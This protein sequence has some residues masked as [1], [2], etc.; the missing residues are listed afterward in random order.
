MGILEVIGIGTIAFIIYQYLIKPSL[1][2]DKLEKSNDIEKVKILSYWHPEIKKMFSDFEKKQ[3]DAERFAKEDHAKTFLYEEYNEGEGD[4]VNVFRRRTYVFY[5]EDI[6]KFK[7]SVN[8]K[9]LELEKIPAEKQKID[10]I[11]AH[12]KTLVIKE[13]E[14]KEIIRLERYKNYLKYKEIMNEIFPNTNIKLNRDNIVKILID[15]LSISENEGNKLFEELINFETGI[16]FTYSLSKKGTE[17][18]YWYDEW[19]IKNKI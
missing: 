11:L 4:Y 7:E 5:K 17:E 9:V 18:T 14:S 10:D 15:K 2:K 16:I 12:Y 8:S 19:Q 13:N 1:D 6:E 3:F